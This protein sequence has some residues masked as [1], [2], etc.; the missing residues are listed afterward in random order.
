M[1]DL[2]R[3]WNG[4]GELTLGAVSDGVFAL[5]Q[6]LAELREE[7]ASLK[8]RLFALESPLTDDLI[9]VHVRGGVYD[10]MIDHYPD[11]ANELIGTILI[12]NDGWIAIAADGRRAKQRFE[13]RIMAGGWLRYAHNVAQETAR[14]EFNERPAP[15]NDTPKEVLCDP[16]TG[17]A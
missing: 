6:E 13:S 5:T 16:F 3:V 1:N 17:G 7:S 8:R 10:V 2:E 9:Y 4:H 11:G 12:T 14:R 15:V